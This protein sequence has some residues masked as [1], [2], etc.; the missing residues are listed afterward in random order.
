MASPL[1]AFT[2]RTHI[3]YFSCQ[4]RCGSQFDAAPDAYLI[5]V[6]VA[7]QIQFALRRRR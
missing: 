4:R 2:L 1:D 7:Q 3:A 6:I 5:E